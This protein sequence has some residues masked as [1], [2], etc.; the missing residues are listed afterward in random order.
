[1]PL[2]V[3]LRDD[4]MPV[5]DDENKEINAEDLPLLF[6][7][8]LP[9]DMRQASLCGC[10]SKEVR[11]RL[12]LMED[13]LSDLRRYRRVMVGLVRK[14]RLDI[15]GTGTKAGTRA[16]AILAGVVAKVARS[17]ARYRMS[18]DALVRVEPRGKWRSW[19]LVLE[20]AD[21]RG[22]HRDEQFDAPHRQ[23]T[24]SW[25]WLMGPLQSIRTRTQESESISSGDFTDE[26]ERS[27]WAKARARHLRCKE[28]IQLL[29]V[30]MERVLMWLEAK[31][32]WWYEQQARREGVDQHL[33]LGL[34]SYARRQASM[35]QLLSHVFVAQW[36][37]ILDN[38]KLGQSW[39][40][41]WPCDAAYAAGG[42]ARIFQEDQK[43]S[44]S[45]CHSDLKHCTN[46][47]VEHPLEVLDG[48][49]AYAMLGASSSGVAAYPSIVASS[50]SVS[51]AIPSIFHMGTNNSLN[52]EPVAA[53]GKNI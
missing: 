29:L 27:E 39:I 42:R 3:E 26:H 48:A 21:I 46:R 1:M 11:L 30:E 37:P 22:P 50:H 25:I 16:R 47:D 28:E 36:T 53:F 40:R 6:P 44:A 19:Y 17:A 43:P 5:S 51:G 34:K 24:P 2:V 14:Y 7:S 13:S 49:S 18:H 52:G 38:A 31:S 45:S 33:A 9:S 15:D 12:A 41:K 20:D 23:Y 35:Y 4:A 8:S 32:K 10:A